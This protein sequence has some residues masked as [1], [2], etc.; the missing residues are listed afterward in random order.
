[1]PSSF[2]W[3]RVAASKSNLARIG[4]PKPY[5]DPETP[6]GATRYILDLNLERS[7]LCSEKKW[8][9]RLPE[10]IEMCSWYQL[11]QSADFR[12]PPRSAVGKWGSGVI[13]AYAVGKYSPPASG[14][15]RGGQWRSQ[16][17]AFG[18]WFCCER[19]GRHIRQ[20]S[21]NIWIDV[22]M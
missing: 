5:I 7:F 15:T 19:S 11:M 6:R 22:L 17:E 20:R 10:F 14:A 9:P 4:C 3:C 12:C 16:G 2:L 1:M 8:C 21:N 13:F 18:G